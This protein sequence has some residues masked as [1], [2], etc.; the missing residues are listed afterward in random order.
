[1]KLYQYFVYILLIHIING[2]MCGGNC[3]TG[4]CPLCLCGSQTNKLDIASWC[5]KYTWNQSCCK[6]IISHGSN[7]NANYI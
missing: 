2:L 3:P 1:M 6:C 5:S 7:S 4:N